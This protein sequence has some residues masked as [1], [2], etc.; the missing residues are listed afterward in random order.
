MSKQKESRPLDLQVELSGVSI[1]DAASAVGIKVDRNRLPYQMAVQTFCGKRIGVLLRTT[2]NGGEDSKQTHAPAD[3]F[4][5]IEGHADVKRVGISPKEISFRLS[6]NNKEV[7][8]HDLADFAQRSGKLIVNTVEDI[9]E[10]TPEEHAP[11][12]RNGAPKANTTGKDEG[13]GQGLGALVEF[14]FPERLVSNLIDACAGD[15][16]GHLEQRMR[17]TPNTYMKGIAGVGGANQEKLVEA[18]EALRKAFP[19][20]EKTLF[21]DAE[22]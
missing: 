12:G 1:G 10:P 20:P 19:M 11:N 4:E 8:P 5:S 18:Y 16:I 9:P 14:G 3:A 7:S 15:T 13:I 21:E 22:K 6:F 2:P 17:T